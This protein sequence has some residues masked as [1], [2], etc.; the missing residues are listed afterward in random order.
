MEASLRE[1][2]LYRP[3]EMRSLMSDVET[4]VARHLE[5]DADDARY[6]VA[7]GVGLPVPRDQLIYD[8][9]ERDP[10]VTFYGKAAFNGSVYTSELRQGEGWTPYVRIKRGAGKYVAKVLHFAKC[11]RTKRLTA[12]CRKMRV[13]HSF[14]FAT[15]CNRILTHTLNSVKG[16]EF[17][18]CDVSA[19]DD[20]LFRVR[21]FLS[22]MPHP[23]LKGFFHNDA[24]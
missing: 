23:E 20:R 19:V 14:K 4:N 16:D 21:N 2:D 10:D 9:H 3:T 5:L 8:A 1:A 11:R 13:D 17:F 6:A 15:A 7:E 12:V 24:A 18:H 22:E